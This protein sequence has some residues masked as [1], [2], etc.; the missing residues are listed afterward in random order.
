M[1][2]MRLGK[3]CILSD[4]SARRPIPSGSVPE[5]VVSRT[6]DVKK[7]QMGYEDKYSGRDVRPGR[8][9]EKS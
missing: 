6:S 9:F 8:S 3:R 1:V 5:F 7:Q 2:W 4:A